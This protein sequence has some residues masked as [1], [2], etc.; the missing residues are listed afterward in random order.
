MKVFYLFLAAVAAGVTGWQANKYEPEINP[1]IQSTILD[2]GEKAAGASLMGQFRTSAAASL[3]QRADLYLHGGTELRPISGVEQQIGVSNAHA[4]KGS[5]ELGDESLMVTS[6]PGPEH[7]FRGLLGDME[8]ETGAY[9]DMAG[10]EHKDAGVTFPLFRLMTWVDPHFITGWT[11][12]SMMITKDR[13]TRGVHEMLDYLKQGL[14]ENPN[15]IDILTRT[16]VLYAQGL[17]E[18]D[19]GEGYFRRAL[20]AVRNHQFGPE[21][22]DAVRETYRWVAILDDRKEDRPDLKAIVQEGLKVFPD[23]QVLLRFAKK[24][25]LPVKIPSSPNSPGQ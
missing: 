17:G 7:D 14:D 10:H 16:G 23:D 5:D 6:I 11:T 19:T 21:D 25:G 8:R 9:R 3:Y 13:T 20:K 15:S 22:A 12:G 2:S 18:I 1:P 24:L 4:R